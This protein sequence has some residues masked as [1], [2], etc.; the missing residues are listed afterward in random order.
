MIEK[1]AMRGQYCLAAFL[2]IEGAFD[3]LQFGSIKRE[4]LAAGT[5]QDVTEWYVHL[6]E[7]R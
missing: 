1:T 3:N 7:N 2:D 6:L 4:L 5:R